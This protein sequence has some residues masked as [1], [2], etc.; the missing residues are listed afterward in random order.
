MISK[1]V[2][3]IVSFFAFFQIALAA[4]NGA[5]PMPASQCNVGSVQCCNTVQSVHSVGLA[6]FFGVVGALAQN[7][8]AL[9]SATC[10]PVSVIGGGGN[11][12]NA[13]PVCCTGNSFTGV[14][15]V[16][17]TPVNINL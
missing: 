8:N 9:V 17:C 3:I 11:S 16:G 14:I 10:N 13:Q 12:C 4:P 1:I 6:S 15:A 5:P 7:P 2:F